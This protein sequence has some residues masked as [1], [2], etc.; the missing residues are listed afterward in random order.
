[1]MVWNGG[2]EDLSSVQMSVAT[3]IVLFVGKTSIYVCIV[4][5]SLCF[6]PVCDVTADT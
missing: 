4:S 2:N 5:V 6:I 1:M 3:N